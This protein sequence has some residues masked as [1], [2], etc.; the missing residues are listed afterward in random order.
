MLNR[1]L[2]AALLSAA[3]LL[4]IAPTTG[5]HKPFRE[6][7]DLDATLLPGCPF[8]VELTPGDG[9]AWLTM[10]DSGRLAIHT[11]ANPTMTNT[12][13]GDSKAYK[14]RYVFQE[15]FDAETN[16]SL[17]QI[18]GRSLFLI[19]P[20]DVGPDGEV[21]P[22]GGLVRIV[23]Q[24]RYAADPETFAITWLDVRGQV[25]DVCEELAS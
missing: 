10:F 6:P 24:L 9:K 18:T 5:A 22:D 19:A 1:N 11:I 3:A 17:G 2:A 4:A 21:D 8:D 25:I 20:G 14:L 12:D 7:I 13:S 15:T 23:G 16:Q